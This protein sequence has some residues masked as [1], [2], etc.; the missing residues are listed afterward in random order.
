MGKLNDPVDYPVTAP[1][2]TDRVNGTDVSNVANDSNGESVQFEWQGVVTL[3]NTSLAIEGTAIAST[4]ETGGTKFLREDG[5]DTSSWQAA[6]ASDPT[7]VTG[8]DVV[9][10]MISLTQAEYDAIGTPD[11]STFY[12][13]TT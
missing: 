9:A 6:V 1:A 10:N 8:A 7:G 12:V 11:A 4:G 13:I 3:F 5:D 2:L